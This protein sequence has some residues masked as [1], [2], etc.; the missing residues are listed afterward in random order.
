MKALD[1]KIGRRQD[2]KWARLDKQGRQNCYRNSGG[3]C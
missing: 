1:A 3:T 2:Q